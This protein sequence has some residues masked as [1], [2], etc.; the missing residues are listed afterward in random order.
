MPWGIL[1]V[2]WS[3]VYWPRKSYIPFWNFS[4]LFPWPGG[5]FYILWYFSFQIPNGPFFWSIIAWFISL[6]QVCNAFLQKFIDAAILLVG[7]LKCLFSSMETFLFYNSILQKWANLKKNKNK[8]SLL[9]Y[10]P[11]F[12]SSPNWK[13][14]SKCCPISKR[15]IRENGKTER[16]IQSSLNT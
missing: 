12:Y 7:L 11:M 1:L 16:K 6:F 5:Y 4:L 9:H 10:S 8:K 14:F 13:T 2:P 15:K 3:E